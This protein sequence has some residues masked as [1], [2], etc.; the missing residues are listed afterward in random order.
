[1]AYEVYCYI[2]PKLTEDEKDEVPTKDSKVE[3]FGSREEAAK[4]AAECKGDWD[5]VILIHADEGKQR[6][7]ERYVDGNHEV[8]PEKQDEAEGAAAQA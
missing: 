3:S 8:M 4:F 5:R 2:I 7:L 1:M 6:M